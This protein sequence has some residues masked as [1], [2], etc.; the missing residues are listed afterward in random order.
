MHVS[1]RP[2]KICPRTSA[3]IFLLLGGPP[4]PVI[5]YKNVDL[6]GCP[7]CTLHPGGGGRGPMPLKGPKLAIFGFRVFFTQIRP[8]WVGDLG[9]RPK[10]FKF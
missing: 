7:E 6:A 9:A 8:V 2:A 3:S 5:S 1:G 10:N 4:G